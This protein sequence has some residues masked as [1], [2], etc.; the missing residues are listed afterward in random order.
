HRPR[1]AIIAQSGGLAFSISLRGAARGLLFSK[2]VSS[3]NEADI[4][5]VDFLDHLVDD[6]GTQVI[7]MFLESIRRGPEFMRAAQRARAAGKSII[8]TKVGR[9]AAG[10]RAAASHTASMTGADAVADAV[11]RSCGVMRCD[12]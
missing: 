1:A 8:V 3:G 7:I 4:D 11:F 12:D 10:A 2:I 5:A 6:P 9:T